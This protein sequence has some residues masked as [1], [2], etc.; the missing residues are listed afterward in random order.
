M[1]TPSEL[2][3]AEATTDD[4]VN[5]DYSP[6]D[7]EEDVLDVLRE[8]WRANP[9]LIRQR[10]GHGK[11][12]VNTALTRLTSAGWVKK[13]TRGLYEFVEDPRTEDSDE[14]QGSIDTPLDGTEAAETVES[15][16]DS[17]PADPIADALAGWSYGRTDDEQAANRT[18]ARASLEWLRDTGE[19]V[20][21]S[22][23]PLDGLAEDDPEERTPDTLWRSVIRGAWQHAVGQGYVEQPDSRSYKWVGGNE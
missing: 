7:T 10:S 19:P 4:M 1:R 18:V 3:K 8:E 21:Q 2:S 13:V 5:R 16:D 17:V 12:T 22:D 14:A 20:R 9:Y 6:S 23:V 11:G 15:H